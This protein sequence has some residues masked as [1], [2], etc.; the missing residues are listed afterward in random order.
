MHQKLEGGLIRRFLFALARVGLYTGF[1]VAIACGEAILVQLCFL[2]LCRCNREE[3]YQLQRDA[4]AQ[5]VTQDLQLEDL[6]RD[7]YL[8]VYATFVVSL[9]VL[10]VFRTQLFFR[11]SIVAS[12]SLHTRMFAALV[13]APSFFFDTNSI[14]N[15]DFVSIDSFS[16]DVICGK[17]LWKQSRSQGLFPTPPTWE[18][19]CCESSLFMTSQIHLIS[20]F[21]T[22][23]V[24]ICSQCRLYICYLG[25]F[26]KNKTHSAFPEMTSL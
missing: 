21:F 7:M 1:F 20:K 14:G 16:N 23:F 4:A 22:R 3:Q 8:G 18:R 15:K 25:E 24:P 11:L 9:L 12:R 13:R 5:N 26:V 19:G 6:N 17:A 2:S 10:T